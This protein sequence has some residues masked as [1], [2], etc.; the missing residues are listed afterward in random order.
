MSHPR[1]AL[2]AHPTRKQLSRAQRERRLRLYIIGGTIAVAA[3]V[4]GVL[5]YGL[6]DLWFLQPRQPVAI[7]NGDRIT[8]DEF[9]R[10][11][12]YQRSRLISNYLQYAAIAQDPTLAQFVQSQISQLESYL[13]NPQLIGQQT[14]DNLIEDRLIRQEA[15]RRGI[16]VSADE[17]EARL[18]EFMDFFPNGTPTPTITPS[19]LPT[20]APPT[21]N[22]TTVAHWTPT[23]TITPTATLTP[24][25]TN[26]PGPTPTATAT[27]TPEPT[28][29][30]V[31]TEAYAQR[32][33]SYTTGLRQQAQLR[34]ADLRRFIESDLYREKV[35]AVL[36]PELV[37][38]TEEQ[39]HVRHILISVPS[40]A[41][42]DEKVVAKARADELLARLRAGEDW[43][44]LAS[45]NS[46]DP[47]YA[48]NYG[49]M[50]WFGRDASFVPEFKDGAFNTAVGEISEPVLSQFGYHLIQV[51]GRETRQRAPAELE[52][53]RQTAFDNWLSE[54]RN[55]D[56][57][58]NVRVQTFDYWIGRVPTIPAL[59]GS[60]Q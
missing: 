17:V 59:P 22:P 1:S 52:Q 51:L 11:V 9:Q 29:T 14:L 7:V 45:E 21:L 47:S 44:L 2:P 20:D 13:T 42:D 50:G 49:D 25:A 10:A 41:T 38:D 46:E 27:D 36:G 6:F 26:T 53:A 37:A 39:V 34:E 12:R 5:G 58:G 16:T 55:P 23:A 30:P 57:Q 35:F 31:S 15:K 24:T 40:D 28:S 8:T 3:I 60:S 56:A 19:P 33:I 4:V 32:V 54:Q 18:R 48:Q 43:D